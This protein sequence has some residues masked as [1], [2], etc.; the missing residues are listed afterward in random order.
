MFLA[1]PASFRDRHSVFRSA[2]S[3]L[4]LL[5]AAVLPCH[6][7]RSGAAPVDRFQLSAETIA[8]INQ[9]TGGKTLSS[10]TINTGIRN[11]VMLL[12]GQ[13]LC[14]G[15]VPTAYTPANPTKLDNLNQADGAIYRAADPLLGT[16]YSI[17]AGVPYSGPAN[18]Y[19]RVADTLVTNNKFDRVILVPGCIGATTVA[20]WAPGGKFGGN[21]Q[22]MMNRLA[23]KGIV[24]GTNVTII[25]IYAQGTTDAFAG[26]SQ[27][28]YTNGLNAFITASRASGF[29]GLWFINTE[30]WNG[31]AVNSAIQNAQAAVVN[32]G[33]NVWAGANQDT[34]INNTCSASA[35]RIAK[36]LLHWTDAGSTTLAAAVVTAL[37]LSGAPF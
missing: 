11:L 28:N 36:D 6:A 8:S 26:T 10:Q 13:S 5:L 1:A 18:P 15:I 25:G 7:Q 4:L 37:G 19:L 2:T 12:I 34:I 21:F 27:A 30:S 22:V 31:A 24:A 3:A 14:E 17:A 35:C 16:A 33:A 9:D 20:D 23:D 29:N 32:H